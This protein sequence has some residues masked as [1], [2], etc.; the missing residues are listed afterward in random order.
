[1][2]TLTDSSL[3]LRNCALQT[4]W[5]AGRATVQDMKFASCWLSKQSLHFF[6]L[7]TISRALW[8]CNFEGSCPSSSLLLAQAWVTAVLQ[9]LLFLSPSHLANELQE[10]QIA[11]LQ[12]CAAKVWFLHLGCLVKR[13]CHS[14][15][16]ITVKGW[17][18]QRMEVMVVLGW[19]KSFPILLQWWLLMAIK[20]AVTG[21]SHVEVDIRLRIHA[22]VI[23][24]FLTIQIWEC[25]AL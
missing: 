17:K 5:K 13:V 25:L 22:C 4:I 16:T 8:V 11:R 12:L 14:P 9:V 24:Q 21:K 7:W 3:S 10:T 20:V 15:V 23:F 6:W 1:M 2:D 19:C 18:N